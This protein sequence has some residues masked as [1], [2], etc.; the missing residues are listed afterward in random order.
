M[1]ARDGARIAYQTTA[2]SK[3][4]SVL[5]I[6]G[7]GQPC[8]FWE[9]SLTARIADSGLGQTRYDHRDTGLSTWFE[10]PTYTF[11][12]L[13]DDAVELIESVT[14]DVA[15]LVG[16]SL[17]GRVA[18]ALAIA[19]PHLV[20]SLV[21]VGSPGVRPAGDAGEDSEIA[22]LFAQ[23]PPPDRVG[24]IAYLARAEHL[25]AVRSHSQEYVERATAW[26]DYGY[27]FGNRHIAV[28]RANGPWAKSRLADIDVPVAVIH[29][30]RDPVVPVDNATGLAS[31]ISGAR[32]RIIDG[33]GHELND[34]MAG[35]ICREIVENVRRSG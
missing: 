33:V 9:D 1:V 10:T 21:L 7:A 2:E 13:V 17:G 12:T 25:V 22:S 31:S 3:Q 11:D 4:T 6:A 35:A 26:I 29:G 28:S 14:R 18:T 15:H 19:H 30:D 23:G 16:F 20:A 8:L 5:L 24:R 32:L 27:N 34:V